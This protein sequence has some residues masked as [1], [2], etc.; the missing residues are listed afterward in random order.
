MDLG[1]LKNPILAIGW[2][3]PQTCRWETSARAEIYAIPAYLHEGEVCGFGEYDYTVNSS[4]RYYGGLKLTGTISGK[5][6]TDTRVLTGEDFSYQRVSN[7]RQDSAERMFKTLKRIKLATDRTAAKFG[8]A[9][10]FAKRVAYFKEAIGAKNVWMWEQDGPNG[11]KSGAYLYEG[12]SVIDKVDCLEQALS[13]ECRLLSGTYTGTAKG[14]TD[15]PESLDF[16]GTVTL[17]VRDGGYREVQIDGV[18]YLEQLERYRSGLFKFLSYDEYWRQS[19]LE[20]RERRSLK[21]A[22]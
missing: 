14:W 6:A 15:A 19:R 10:T 13:I 18:G 7:V 8:S 5:Y 1:I 17:E 11:E 4:D 16:L 20:S 2:T 21:A 3:R 12:V 9:D 22:I